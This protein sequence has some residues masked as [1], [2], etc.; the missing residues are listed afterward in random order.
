MRMPLS[1]PSDSKY[2]T[3]LDI[4]LTMP[5]SSACH[6]KLTMSWNTYLTG[7]SLILRHGSREMTSI[8]IGRNRFRYI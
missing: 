1:V 5:G 4:V 2:Y 7:Q 3:P 8:D 6:H